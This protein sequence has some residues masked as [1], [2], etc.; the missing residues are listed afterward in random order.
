MR[1]PSKSTPSPCRPITRCQPAETIHVGHWDLVE[2]IDK[3]LGELFAP[4]IEEGDP[5]PVDDY[6]D[7]PQDD[8]RSHDHALDDGGIDLDVDAVAWGK[9]IE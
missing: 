5:G 1:R 6:P 9:A 3:G 7:L 8:E 2:E 4:Q